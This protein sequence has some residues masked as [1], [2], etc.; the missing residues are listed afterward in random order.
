M[1]LST[2]VAHPSDMD[3]RQVAFSFAISR[4]PEGFD[5]RQ[6]QSRHLETP[7]AKEAARNL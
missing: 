3:H 7:A 5:G 4:G 1:A 6:E 2:E